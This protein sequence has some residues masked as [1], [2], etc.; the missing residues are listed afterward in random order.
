MKERGVDFNFILNQIIQCGARRVTKF[1]D[2]KE[3]VRVTRKQFGGK[4][5]YRQYDLVMTIGCKQNYR[6]R[7]YIKRMKKSNKKF[8]VARHT[9][10]E[11]PKQKV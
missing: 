5:D 7:K 4:F 6:E 3:V 1:I 10:I 2:E 11:M 8:V 9:L